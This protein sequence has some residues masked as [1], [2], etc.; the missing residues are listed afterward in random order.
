MLPATLVAFFAFAID[1][2]NGGLTQLAGSPF[3]VGPA[4]TSCLAVDPA[5]KFLY[6][7]SYTGAIGNIWGFALDSN[8]GALTSLSGSPFLH[9][10][11]GPSDLAVISVG[12]AKR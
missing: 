2:N 10:D 3:A 1:P 9:G 8:T 12:G 6:V 7:T 4:G 5:G 11:S